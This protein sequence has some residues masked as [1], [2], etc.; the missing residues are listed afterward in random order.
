MKFLLCKGL[1]ILVALLLAT[2]AM[3]AEGAGDGRAAD[4]AALRVLMAKAVQA[5]NE[6]DMDALASCFTKNF[7]FTTVDQAVLTNT[8]ALRNYYDQ[9]LKSDRSPVSSFKMTPT[10][11]IPTIFLDANTGYSCGSSDDAYTLRKGGKV[12]HIPSR[13]TAMVVRE[14]GQWKLAAV[15]AGV[16]F[17]DNPLLKIKTLPWWRKCLLAVGL[18]KYP[19]E[20][21][22]GE[23]KPGEK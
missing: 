22:R 21:N 12:I 11:E 6:Q 8:T 3:A 7:A 10:V 19:G 9:M 16:N 13:W 1:T 5:I 4:H 15:H 18:G 2:G 23:K 20:N 14:E 17:V